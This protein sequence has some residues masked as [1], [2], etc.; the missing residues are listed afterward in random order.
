[1]IGVQSKKNQIQDFKEARLTTYIIVAIFFVIS[2]ICLL[3]LIVYF[4]MKF[5]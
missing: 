5:V 1:M 4:V 2:L 3:K